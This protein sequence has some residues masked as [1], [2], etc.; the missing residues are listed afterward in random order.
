[1]K[2]LPLASVLTAITLFLV[3][4]GGGVQS[5]LESSA[6]AGNVPEGLVVVYDDHHP[7]WGGMRITVKGDRSLSVERWRPNQPVAAPD[8]WEGTVPPSA[9][10]ALVQLLVDIEAWEQ[11]VEADETRIDDARARLEVRVG[12]E[13][14]ATWEWAN[15]LEANQR[16]VQVKRHLEAL[17]FEAR[18]PMAP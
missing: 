18:H 4:C 17:A 7:R 13:R 12:G 5:K 15:D 1:M 11:K 9:M 8:R 2:R 10:D 3:G 6:S 16:I 14:A